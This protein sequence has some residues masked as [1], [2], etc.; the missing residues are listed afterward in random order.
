MKE[1]VSSLRCEVERLRA[2]LEAS[3]EKD[4]E[5]NVEASSWLRIQAEL[6]SE[7]KTAKYKIDK[8]NARLAAKNTELKFMS[9]EKDDLYLLLKKNQKETDAEPNQLIEKLKADLGL[10]VNNCS[11]SP[12]SYPNRSS[13]FGS[14]A[15]PC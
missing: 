9:E 15:D 1:E 2:A 4:Q 8:L 11:R 14:V 12:Y 3:G 5:G 6:Q 13:G 10:G 7:L